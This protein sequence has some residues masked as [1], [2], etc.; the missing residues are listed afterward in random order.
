MPILF[1]SAVVREGAAVAT[2]IGAERRSWRSAA[3]KRPFAVRGTSTARPFTAGLT[4]T[5]PPSVI[6]KSA[7]CGFV[8]IVFASRAKYASARGPPIFSV[9]VPS[10]GRSR[11]CAS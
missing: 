10:A 5:P 7:F 3:A 4:T 2:T 1:A 9:F 8:L 6:T 11:S